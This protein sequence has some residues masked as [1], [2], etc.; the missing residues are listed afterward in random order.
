M[1]VEGLSGPV[2]AAHIHP[3]AAGEKNPPLVNLDPETLKGS[4]ELT[5]EQALQ[6]RTGD[7]Y[8]NVHSRRTR[9]ARSVGSS[10]IARK[11]KGTMTNPTTVRGTKV[12]MAKAPLSSRIASS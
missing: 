12:V 3:G 2:V 6:I 11:G 9:M 1:K 4:V 7:N 8:V 10:R 5:A